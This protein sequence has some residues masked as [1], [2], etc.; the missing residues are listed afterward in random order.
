MSNDSP[1]PAPESDDQ[2]PDLLA[3]QDS[4]EARLLD[5][6]HLAEHGQ[7]SLEVAVAALFGRSTGRVTLD[8]E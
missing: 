7:H 1:M 8:D 3:R 6:E 2:W 4:V 5:V